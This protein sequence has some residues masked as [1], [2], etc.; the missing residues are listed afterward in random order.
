VNNTLCVDSGQMAFI[1]TADTTEGAYGALLDVEPGQYDVF[2]E[3]RDEGSWGVRISAFAIAKAKI[4]RK[5]KEQ[6]YVDT[7]NIKTNKIIVSD[8][9]YIHQDEYGTSGPYDRACDATSNTKL[10]AGI[11]KLEDGSNAACSSTGFGDGSYPLHVE[12]DTNGKV[13]YAEVRFI[14]EYENDEDDYCNDS[15]DDGYDDDS[16]CCY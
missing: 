11:Y 7:L 15:Y 3:R 9:C 14:D 5:C 2:I 16:E 4:P 8:P 6:I 10:M 13:I 12:C 1:P